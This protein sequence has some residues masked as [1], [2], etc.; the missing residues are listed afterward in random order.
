LKL[1]NNNVCSYV[2]NNTK[3]TKKIPQH[4][5]RLMIEK[6][7]KEKKISVSVE[8]LEYNN[9]DHLPILFHALEKIR[10][11]KIIIFSVESINTN[12]ECIQRFLKKTKNTKKRICFA[13]EGIQFDSIEAKKIIKNFR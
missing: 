12:H 11:R 1:S 6:F 5:Q 3:F 10:F 4:L 13:N 9:M 8:L 7:C 2:N